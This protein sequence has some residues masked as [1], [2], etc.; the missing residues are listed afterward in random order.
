MRYDNNREV[1]ALW[2][3]DNGKVPLS[4][5]ERNKRNILPNLTYLEIDSLHKDLRFLDN[6]EA[7]FIN[8]AHFSHMLLIISS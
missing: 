3:K 1:L 2:K 7:V 8:A 6:Q 4:F 5:G